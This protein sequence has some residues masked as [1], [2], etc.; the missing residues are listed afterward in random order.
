[1]AKKKPVFL[2]G[3]LVPLVVGGAVVGLAMTGTI[4]IPGL[5]PQ[6]AAANIY[7]QANLYGE[8][9]AGGDA[10]AIESEAKAKEETEGEKVPK[11]P[12]A[13][14]K[15]AITTEEPATDPDAGAKKLA[16]LWNV[17]ETTTLKEIAPQFKDQELALIVSKM[18]TEK[19]AALLAVMDPKRAAII[20]REI[21]E[22]GSIIPEES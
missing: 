22:I 12:A 9:Q 17:M 10:L 21:Q 6:K 11:P 4:K 20:S 7:G 1:M 13:P 19:A 3:A 8:S 16:K 15:L 14:P 18:E 2:I 5:T